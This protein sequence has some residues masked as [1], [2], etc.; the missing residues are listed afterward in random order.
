MI[1]VKK[2]VDVN[3]GDWFYQEIM[4]AS[5]IELEDGK[6]FV[7]GIPYNA[8]KAGAPY[9]YEEHIATEGQKV[10]SLSQKIVP[11]IDNPLYVFIDG[12]QTVYEKVEDNASGT[13]DVTLYGAPRAG[14]VVSFTSWGIPETD[15]FGKPT[16]PYTGYYPKYTLSRASNYVYDK[17]NRYYQEYV[18]V[19]GRYLRR[20]PVPDEEW[21]DPSIWEQVVQKYIGY[22][23]DIYCITPTGT[24]YM[25]Y[26]FNNVTCTIVYTTQE[27]WGLKQNTEQFKP[28]SPMVYYN[29]RFFPNAYITR[30]EAYV[31]INRL[32][33]TFYSRFTDLE[34]PG[35]RLEQ[36]IVAYEGQTVFRL[37]GTYPAGKEK[38]LVK[39]NGVNKEAGV[40]YQ[41]TDAHTVTFNT[42]LHEGD[43]VYFFYEKTVST[44]FAD[45]GVPTSMVI[46]G[47]GEVIKET[48]WWTQDIL[49]ME[50]E[51][52]RSTGQPLISGILCSYFDANGNVVVDDMYNPLEGTSQP[53]LMFMPDSLLTRAEAVTFLNR[54]RKW[55]LERF[56]Y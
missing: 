7:S 33:K 10:F 29:N 25:P 24:V 5:R 52:I 42:G 56:K 6:P 23:T 26:N 16:P 19:F 15:K 49:A 39:V 2:W 4:E 1:V 45:V 3:E 12:V 43:Q 30:A 9:I 44:R 48:D 35:S 11:T 13:S 32:R 40:D 31:L 50:D 18:Y 36:T 34:P 55:A 53:K 47:T 21:S 51:V 27:P 38:L 46:L 37:N 22:D 41:E 54:F 14:A 28:T 8:F 20:A 17:F